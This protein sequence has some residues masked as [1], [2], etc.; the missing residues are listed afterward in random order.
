MMPSILWGV[1]HWKLILLFVIKKFVLH[2]K[3]YMWPKGHRLETVSSLSE[4]QNFQ[5]A[6]RARPFISL[7]HHCVCA[8]GDRVGGLG[9]WGGQG[10]GVG[11]WCQ[12]QGGACLARFWRNVH[13]YTWRPSAV[14]FV[15]FIS[16]VSP[17]WT[18]A[19]PWLSCH[20]QEYKY[21]KQAVAVSQ[22]SHP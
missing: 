3:E 14:I 6:L 12:G 10:S 15:C 17:L 21:P 2:S 13:R 16:S 18:L 19:N 20:P 9:G 7:G 4:A 22:E 8:V 5:P 1:G 11:R